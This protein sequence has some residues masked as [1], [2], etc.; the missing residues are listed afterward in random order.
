MISEIVGY[1]ESTI[2][3]LDTI[4]AEI[5]LLSKIKKLSKMYS[6]WAGYNKIKV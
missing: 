4:Y 1:Q 6:F 3:T 2:E 5:Y